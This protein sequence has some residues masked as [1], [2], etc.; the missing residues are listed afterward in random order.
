[1]GVKIM[2]KTNLLD[3]ARERYA[4]LGVDVDKA[5]ETL[6]KTPISIHCWQGDD[7]TG[8]E[9]TAGGLTGGIQ[10]T[11]NY[12]GK[13]RTPE[14]LRADMDKML[15]LIPGTKKINIHASYLEANKKVDRDEILPEHFDNWINWANE[16]GIGLDFNSTSFSHPKGADGYTLSHKDKGIRDFWIEHTIRVR[17]ISDYIGAKTGKLCLNNIWIHDGEKEV[18]VDTMGPRVRLKDS[19]DKI[20]AEKMDEKNHLDSLES[21]LFGIGSEAYVPGSHEFYTAYV[22]KRDDCLLT[23]DTGHFHPTEQVSAKVS[24]LAPFVKGLLLHVSRPIRWDSDHVVSFDDETTAVMREVVKND[25]LDKVYF[26]TDYF[27]ASINRIF[28]WAVGVR[29]AQKALLQALLLP[30]ELLK[31]V[32]L[33]NDCSSRLALLEESKVLP[34]GIVWE[35]YLETKGVPADFAWHGDVKKYESEVL[36][37]RS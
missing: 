37:K 17:K 1:M 14:E 4:K 20:F 26:A 27:D 3:Y 16:R 23:L 10:T 6:D 19:L 29:N 7:V 5:I 21:K 13:A 33:E 9:N 30:V 15:A 35:H 34:L 28:A 31:K 36:S 24:A 18:P 32:E 25:L 22:A 12:P 8:F 2:S 11:G